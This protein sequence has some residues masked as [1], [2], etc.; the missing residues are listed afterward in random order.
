MIAL[1]SP[2]LAV[3]WED[4]LGLVLALIA[5]VYLVVVLIAPERF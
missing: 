1:L 5:V 3:Q 2:V 4:G